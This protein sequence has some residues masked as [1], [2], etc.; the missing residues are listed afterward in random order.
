MITFPDFLT[1]QLPEVATYLFARREAILANWRTAC[2]SDPSMHAPMALSREEFN[3]KVPVM[4]N[5]LDQRLRDPAQEPDIKSRAAEHGLHRWHK[6]YVLHELLEEMKYLHQIL[7]AELRQYWMM[8]ESVD[9]QLMATAYDLIAWFSDQT[10]DGSVEQY[11]ALQHIAAND[12][13]H[14]LERALERLNELTRQ[15]GDLLRASS[16]DL[17]GS[18]GLINSA[19]YLLKA[20][21]MSESER[22]QMQ[23]MLNRNLLSVREMVVQLMDLARLEAGQEQVNIKQIDVSHLIRTQLETYQPLAQEQ[24]LM[25]VVDGPEELQIESDSV[26]IQRI[27]QNV[28][29]NALKHTISG[30]VSVSWS[31]EGDYRW[32]LSIQDTGP[33]L[34]TE[35]TA[36]ITQ[37]LAPT[38]D[39]TSGFGVELPE[40]VPTETTAKVTSTGEGIGLSIVKRLCELLRASLDIETKP[41]VGTLF[42]IRLP[43]KWDS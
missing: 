24:G 20:D 15:R 42:R 6:G 5:L 29:L 34:P 35:S 17:R 28:T 32:A 30:F 9:K 7:R 10:I 2:E 40:S 12:R 4:L 31:R 1:A 11:T 25:L 38:I 33:G 3:D 41:E 13:V 19:A 37:S 36:G 18:F 8:R 16:H 26:L 27:L 43:I 14:T 22:E 21:G 23:D 39:S